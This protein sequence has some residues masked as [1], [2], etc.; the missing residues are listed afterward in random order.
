MLSVIIPVTKE[1]KRIS[2]GLS[3]YIS[4]FKEN[5]QNNFELII[6]SNGCTDLE[7][8]FLK[9]NFNNKFL[10]KIFLQNMGKG[11]AIA[12]GFKAAKGS[13]VGFIDMDDSF[14]HNDIKKVIKKVEGKSDCVIGSK[15]KNQKFSSVNENFDKKILSR[16]WNII[17]K[18]LFGFQF[19]DTQAGLKFMKKK[20]LDDIG[21]EFLCKGFEF[22]VELL[23]RI[24]K[25]GYFIEE[26][27]IENRFEDGSTFKAYHCF[28]MLYN[29]LKLKMLEIRNE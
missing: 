10:R 22:D 21:H 11:S 12:E 25:K 20:V 13:V 26:E 29:V 4:F 18:I 19:E 28:P 15:W 7:N 24:G 16:I 17:V 2:N 14:N 5:F 9:E 3:S 27:F 8:N 23:N 1:D 6:V